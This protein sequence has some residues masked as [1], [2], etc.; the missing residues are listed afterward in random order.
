M[1]PNTRFDYISEEICSLYVHLNL[2]LNLIE[3][4]LNTA[5]SNYCDGLQ[6]TDQGSDLLD[7]DW[8]FCIPN[9]FALIF[10]KMS[11]EKEII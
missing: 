8:W 11:D 9:V 7:N 4:H 1:N 6:R 5:V 3:D 2:E 10:K